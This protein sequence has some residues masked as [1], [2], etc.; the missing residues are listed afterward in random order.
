M[1]ANTTH[2]QFP[3]PSDPDIK[4]WRYMDFTKFASLFED[5]SIFFSRADKLG[6]PFEGSYSKANA[7]DTIRSQVYLDDAKRLRMPIELVIEAG[8]SWSSHREWLRQW[9]MISCWH[10]NEFES[11]AMWNLYTTSNES[12]CI[13]STYRKL[14]NV[15]PGKI[16][17]GQVNYLD[18]SQDWIDEGNVFTP[19]MHKR[20]SFEHEREVRAVYDISPKEPL[21]REK[22]HTPPEYGIAQEIDLKDL[23]ENIY[24]APYSPNWFHN[25]VSKFTKRYGYNFNVI[26]SSLEDEPFY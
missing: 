3:Q 22:G 26:K 11:A 6:D 10:M 25:L 24:V 5:K 12:I 19:Y 8:K 21:A 2:P 4:I 18:Y 14:A 16:Y 17:I 9:M 20:K 23:I 7:D 13:Q 15:L 1:P